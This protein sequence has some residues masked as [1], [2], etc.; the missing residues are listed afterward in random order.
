MSSS[1][2]FKF[3]SQKEPSRVTFDGTGI[4]VFELK[5][6]IISQSRLGDG[7]DF[8]LSI[9]NEDTKEGECTLS[10]LIRCN[11]SSDKSFLEYDDDTTIIPR[12]TSVIARRLPAARPG[13]GG[14][15]RYV[16]GKM[17]VNAR[18]ASRAES[19]TTRATPGTAAVSSNVLELN[20]A[21]TEEEKINALF[22]LQASQW[23]EQQ[24]EM[25][26]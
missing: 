4:S 15:A 11:T 13:K 25:A 9:Y 6:E 10:N 24:Q 3:K 26:K 7:T 14:A 8:E 16:S 12:S 23:K 22:N 5:R 19:S 20:N 21:Q 2:H 1:V 17:P 18:S